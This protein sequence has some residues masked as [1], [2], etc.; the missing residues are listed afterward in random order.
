MASAAGRR[1]QLSARGLL[2]R[3]LLSV[4]LLVP[5]SILGVL[6]WEHTTGEGG[7]V[8]LERDGAEYFRVLVPLEIALVDAQAA[9]VAGRPVPRE[10]LDRTVR[11]VA[12]VDARVG[13]GLHSHQRWGEVRAKI[14]ALP[15]SRAQGAEAV[16]ASYAETTDMLLALFD[17]V[18]T[19]SNLILDP[20]TD[21]DFLQDGVTQEL[22]GTIAAAGELADL[23]VV[24]AGKTG[25]QRAT[26]F[27]DLLTRRVALQG[28]MGDLVDD[29]Q[30]AVDSTRSPTLGG[31][32]L[33]RLDR[34]RRVV[35]AILP[36]TASLSE[37]ASTVDAALM[38]RNR[39]EA[40]TA[41]ADLSQAMLRELDAL[42]GQ[43][44]SKLRGQVLLGIGS[45]L[46][47]VVL[48]AA[49]VVAD[50]LSRRR[51]ARGGPPAGG[52]GA[53]P[54]PGV[55]ARQE[56]PDQPPAADTDAGADTWERYVA[57]R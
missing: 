57:S 15:D 25:P 28:G 7:F 5:I 47:I 37:P 2:L 51:A 38:T 46:A 39:A 24:I 26:V 9:A 36:A 4:A 52:A 19:T 49:G 6:T 14:E 43:R 13:D 3:S 34:L 42:L 53:Q 16:F 54:R 22:P 45:V 50:V 21:T 44:Q 27:A 48:M 11:A 56:P 35:D 1:G 32:L 29:I 41:A 18:R 55:H 10:N 20:E 8:D 23:T 17:K 40:Q 12:A 33:G 30:A 31:N